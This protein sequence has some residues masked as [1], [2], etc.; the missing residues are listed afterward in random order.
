MQ[1]VDIKDNTV[2]TQ[3][4]KPIIKG[5]QLLYEEVD[6]DNTVVLKKDVAH[7][8]DNLKAPL[9]AV[10]DVRMDE[11]SR[12]SQRYQNHHDLTDDMLNIMA[13]E[14]IEEGFVLA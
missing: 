2:A 7:I 11:V 13:E 8:P 9:E 6:L 14:I 4:D 5:E 3:V 10:P 12:V 1:E